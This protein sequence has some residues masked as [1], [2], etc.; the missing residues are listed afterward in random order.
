MLYPHP[1][2]FRSCASRSG[3]V[4]EWAQPSEGLGWDNRTIAPIAEN[5]R[6][7]GIPQNLA[8]SQDRRVAGSQDR[9]IAE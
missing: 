4:L 6:I 2:A 9:R 5:R 7:A 8:E 3:G 1:R